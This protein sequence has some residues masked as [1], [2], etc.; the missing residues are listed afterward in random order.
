MFKSFRAAFSTIHG[1][2]S[3]DNIGLISE[4]RDQAEEVL[5]RVEIIYSKIGLKINPGKT[6]IY[7][8]QQIR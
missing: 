7:F 3:A 5:T 4:V 6:E 2:E 1:R 8:R